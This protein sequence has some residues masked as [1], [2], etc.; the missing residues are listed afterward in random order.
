MIHAIGSSLCSGSPP[1]RSFSCLAFGLI[2]LRK[3]SAPP[4]AHAVKSIIVM[5]YTQAHKYPAFT[6]IELLT[7]VAVIAVLAAVVAPAVQ[8]AVNSAQASKCVNNLRMLHSGIMLYTADNDGQIP[9][10][11]SSPDNSLPRQWHRRISPYMDGPSTG[12]WRDKAGETYRCPSDP[13]PYS[14]L[15]SYGINTRFRN[16]KISQFSGESNP[17]LLADATSFEISSTLSVVRNVSYIHDNIAQMI[18]LDGSVQRMDKE[19]IKPMGE[20]TGFWVP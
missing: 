11:D 8:R 12:E 17:V 1:P 7:C 20:N 5:R 10:E 13:A 14:D 9:Y 19:H 15:L 4:Q 18:F 6:L 3:A 16:L 2:S